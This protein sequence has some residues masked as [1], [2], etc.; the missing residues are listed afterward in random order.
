MLE[1]YR[2]GGRYGHRAHHAY[3]STAIQ[4]HRAVSSFAALGD[5][6]D[7]LLPRSSTSAPSSSFNV[8]DLSP[9][10]L[11]T[12]AVAFTFVVTAGYISLLA[13]GGLLA[14][15]V[16]GAVVTC[17]VLLTVLTCATLIT[18][19]VTGVPVGY[20]LIRLAMAAR[21]GAKSYGSG[22]AAAAPGLFSGLF[23]GA[24]KHHH[25]HQQQQ[26][27]DHEEENQ[28]GAGCGGGLNGR[29]Y[30]GASGWRFRTDGDDE[31]EEE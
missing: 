28:Q 22:A 12:A 26:D 29:P 13:A 9:N 20:A 11:R 27:D 3:Q 1:V 24:Q 8:W 14:I 23:G 21:N 17:C 2:H 6:T 18:L 31:G 7:A 5:W 16:T 10:K 4:P 15:L 19:I 25:H 30:G